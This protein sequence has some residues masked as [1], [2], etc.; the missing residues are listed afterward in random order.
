MRV[1]ATH[2]ARTPSQSTNPNEPPRQP[3]PKRAGFPNEPTL[4]GNCQEE[5]LAS[6]PFDL[7]STGKSF[8]REDY[9]ALGCNDLR[10]SRCSGS[11]GGG[12]RRRGSSASRP[13]PAMVP[14]SVLGPRLGQQLGLER[15][16]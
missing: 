4:T 16:P 1:R 6:I 14:G 8:L 7:N 11:G 5:T 12:C 2:V 9:S 10:R 3:S 13:L 15:L